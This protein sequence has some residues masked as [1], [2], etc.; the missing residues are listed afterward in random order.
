MSL[1]EIKGNIVPQLIFFKPQNSL[2]R[3]PFGENSPVFI[4][5]LCFTPECSGGKCE[6]MY[7]RMKDCPNNNKKILKL[8]QLCHVFEYSMYF[9]LFLHGKNFEWWQQSSVI[10]EPLSEFINVCGAVYKEYHPNIS[11]LLRYKKCCCCFGFFTPKKCIYHAAVDAVYY[12]LNRCGL[13]V[14]VCNF[15]N[16]IHCDI[17]IAIKVFPKSRNVLN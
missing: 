3:F 17:K 15:A 5:K 2:V 6:E 8:D 7:P 1:L 14:F 16:W 9:F 11:E 12:F 10:N 4:I 13:F